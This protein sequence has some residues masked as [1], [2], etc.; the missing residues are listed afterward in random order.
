MKCVTVAS[1]PNNPGLKQL[2]RSCDH[3]GY[4][5]IILVDGACEW[6]R[7][8]IGV[9]NWAKNNPGVSYVY[10]DGYDTFFVAPPEELEQKI[11]DR[12]C[13]MIVSGEGVVFPT[14]FYGDGFDDSGS[15]WNWINGGCYWTT[16]DY[17]VRLVE[18]SN[19]MTANGIYSFG[20]LQGWN[21]QEWLSVMHLCF[22]KDI[23]IDTQCEIVQPLRRTLWGVAPPNPDPDFRIGDSRLIN[24]VTNSKPVIIHG[25]GGIP[26]DKIYRLI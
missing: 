5:L 25:N 13:K 3:F 22:R 8:Q 18:G 20:K 2:Q 1:D 14:P 19:Y 7:Q 21:D 15:P 12:N 23:K 24:V 6:G 26:M 4:E 9:Y 17:F 11:K 10:V 16:T